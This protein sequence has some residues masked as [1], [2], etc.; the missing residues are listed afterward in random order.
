MK[1]PA[2]PPAS[3]TDLA[4]RLKRLQDRRDALEMQQRKLRVALERTVERA[5]RVADRIDA[6]RLKTVRAVLDRSP[7]VVIN[8]SVA[9]HYHTAPVAIVREAGRVF[10][11]AKMVSD[12]DSCDLP[13]SREKLARRVSLIVIPDQASDTTQQGGGDAR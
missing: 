5:D 3:L 6:V 10:I 12:E 2:N 8:D 1:S 13:S 11:L 7:D 9:W 4:V